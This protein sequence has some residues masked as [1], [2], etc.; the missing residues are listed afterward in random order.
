MLGDPSQQPAIARVTASL[1]R[2]HSHVSPH[3]FLTRHDGPLEQNRR[4]H[5][6][7]PSNRGRRNQTLDNVRHGTGGP[8]DFA[9]SW[10]MDESQDGM[11]PC[12]W[13]RHTWTG[14]GGRQVPLFGEP[15]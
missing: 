13:W 14:S 4:A 5:S 6:T 3:P 12:P 8:S 11:Q 15:D 1:T 2:W 7:G 9:G 10:I